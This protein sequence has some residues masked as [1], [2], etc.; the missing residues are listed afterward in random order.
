M[1][2]C[3]RGKKTASERFVF[4]HQAEQQMLWLDRRRAELRRPRSERRKITRR[5]FFSIAFEHEYLSCL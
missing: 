5:A 4:A 2:I 3:A 1:V